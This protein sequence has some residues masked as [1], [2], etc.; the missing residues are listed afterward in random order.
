MGLT[1]AVYKRVFKCGYD[2]DREIS[3]FSFLNDATVR[4]KLGNSEVKKIRKYLN[5][6]DHQEVRTKLRNQFT[7]SLDGTSSYLFI[8]IIM[9]NTSGY[10]KCISKTSI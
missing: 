2:K 8:E 1:S 10:G 9:E 6:A 7:H 5:S 4:R 3:I